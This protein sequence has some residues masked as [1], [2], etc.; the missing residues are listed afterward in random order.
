VAEPIEAVVF[1][2]DDTLFDHRGSVRTA[3]GAW[4]RGLGSVAT[5]DLVEAWLR[6]EERHFPRWRSG[7]ISWVEQ[8]RERLRDFLPLIGW[9][10]Q[11]TSLRFALLVLAGLAATIALLA[12][13]LDEPRPAPATNPARA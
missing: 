9:L 1:D 2:L 6:V 10:A 4:L 3:L 11:L 13:H 12:Q 8:R 5:D 7:E